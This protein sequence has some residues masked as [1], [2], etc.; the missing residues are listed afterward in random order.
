M[1]WQ[2]VGDEA[3]YGIR[4]LICR[5]GDRVEGVIDDERVIAGCAGHRIDGTHDRV[6]ENRGS[7]PDR[8]VVERDPLD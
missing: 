3:L 4:P 5:F 1:V 8:P 6:A 7:I 2:G